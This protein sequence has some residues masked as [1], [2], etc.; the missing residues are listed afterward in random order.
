MGIIKELDVPVNQGLAMFNKAV[1]KIYMVLHKIVEQSTKEDFLVDRGLMLEEQLR[2]TKIEDVTNQT[3]EG[4]TAE[5]A[6][7]VS[8]S[9][10]DNKFSLKY[11]HLPP[12]IRNDPELMKYVVKGTNKQWEEALKYKKELLQ[13]GTGGF[14]QISHEIEEKFKE[15]D[16]KIQEV[17]NRNEMVKGEKMHKCKKFVK[18]KRKH[19]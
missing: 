15:K 9:L 3:L 4:D 8:E 10:K 17:Y 1:R 19:H 5:G 13:Y 12:E 11:T 7:I 2:V 18:S 14:V 6:K 16:E